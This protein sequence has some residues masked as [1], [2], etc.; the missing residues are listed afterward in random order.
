MIDK[1]IEQ[2]KIEPSRWRKIMANCTKHAVMTIR[3]SSRLLA[4]SIDFN[5]FIKI[6]TIHHHNQ[7]K[8]QYINGVVFKKDVSSRRMR[9]Q[10]ENPKILLLNGSLGYVQE[11]DGL[12]DIPA[13]ISQQES[14]IRIIRQKIK[15][16]KPDII[17]VE[18][19]ASRLA[20]QV[21]EEDKITVVTNTSA[22]MLKMIARQTQTI[23][24]PS[25]NLL[26]KRFVVGYCLNFRIEPIKNAPKKN[27]KS[28]A[29]T[30]SLMFLEGCQAKLGCSIVLSGP[31]MAEIKLVRKALKV[32]LKTA[33]ILLIERELFRFFVPQIED[34]RN[35]ES[36]TQQQQQ[37]PDSQTQN[38]EHPDLQFREL[39]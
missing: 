36:T 37:E 11:D 22:K 3:P 14:F 32:C 38:D 1:V 35:A 30:T 27:H 7:E 39:H 8:C 5:S 33:R 2:H 4:D 25:T 10:I 34:F 16:L 21:L 28:L 15:A 26:D 12:I 20:L 13:E 29:E 9:T 24:C 31:D 17:F 19:D 23:V 6:V 18:K